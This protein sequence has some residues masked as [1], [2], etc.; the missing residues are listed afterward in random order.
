MAAVT[1]EV[2]ATRRGHELHQDA[3]DHLAINHGAQHLLGYTWSCV[4]RT[5][6]AHKVLASS[7]AHADER[8]DTPA[9]PSSPAARTASAAE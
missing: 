5:G 9:S 3:V 2:F 6:G 4:R 8:L 1:D 7:I